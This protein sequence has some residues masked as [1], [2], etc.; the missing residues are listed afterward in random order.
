V[1]AAYSAFNVWDHLNGLM[2]M[3]SD[4]PTPQN[5]NIKI[6]L[7][8]SE[9]IKDRLQNAF[10]IYN[11]LSLKNYAGAVNSTITMV[12]HF[13]YPPNDSIFVDRKD[14]A[15][16]ME[17]KKIV[18]SKGF[19]DK[20]FDDTLGTNTF[21]LQQNTVL[22]SVLFE[23]DRQAIKLVRRLSGFLNDVM[24]SGEDSK[25]LSKV[26]ESYAVPAGSYKRKRNSWNSIDL[27]AYVG[28]FYGKEWLGDVDEGG[29]MV[30]G[31]T[32]PI[33]FSFNKTFGRR[34][35]ARNPL[36][37]DLIRNQDKI[38]ISRNTIRRRGNS[39]FTLDL[40]V[41]DLAAVVSY[42]I[43]N[44]EEKGLPQDVKWAQLFSPGLKLAYGI[45]GTPLV[46]SFGYQYTPQLRKFDAVDP[47]LFS[48]H[49]LYF[50][51]LFD[52]PLMHIWQS[53]GK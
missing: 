22:T 51:L 4:I 5:E 11:Q 15:A 7:K 44:T 31:L 53:G 24:L 30:Y 19:A 2:V 1:E 13:L 39:T 20:Y 46:G 8:N 26:V 50:G 38:K 36:T 27:N 37:E 29:G 34:L 21:K 16:Y 49:R 45:P 17:A 41:V 43:S 52:L 33:G 14:V 10:E 3:V 28:A 9:R 35:K 18:V 12:E 23:R 32:A 48:A 47:K 6:L 25:K 40:S 42:R